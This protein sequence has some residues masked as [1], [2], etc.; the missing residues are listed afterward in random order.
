M[1][2][3]TCYVPTIR[4]DLIAALYHERIRRGIPMTRLINE[5]IERALH[6]NQRS[7]VVTITKS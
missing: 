7:S 6:S 3:P 5:I 2:R 1:A 4:R